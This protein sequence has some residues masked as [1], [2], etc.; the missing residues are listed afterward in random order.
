MQSIVSTASAKTI[1]VLMDGTWNEPDLV[2]D[3]QYPQGD[4]T[5]IEK[6]QYLI[7]PEGQK[8]LYFRGVGT[9]GKQVFKVVDGAFGNTAEE[10]VVEAY[11]QVVA[12][13]EPGDD[14]AIFGFSRGAATSRILARKLHDEG[15]AG[16][17][18]VIRFLGLFDTVAA[19]GV[20]RPKLDEFRKKFH[21]AKA[22]LQIPVEV[23][24]VVH[25]VAIDED[26]ALFEPTLLS[27]DSSDTKADE[28]W[29]SG[30]HGDI[31]GGWTKERADEKQ[32]AAIAL[33]YMI[34]AAES[35]GIG[36]VDWQAEVQVP[37]NGE[38]TVHSISNVT[39]LAGG[40]IVRTLVSFGSDKPRL[41]VSVREKYES[42]STYRPKQLGSGFGGVILVDS[43]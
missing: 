29:F 22:R 8:V 41:H 38:G 19:L 13:F 26:R 6:L 40:D 12:N 2:S 16:S 17:Q 24:H 32:L 31:G 9:D 28:V 1:V 39:S 14:L 20:P 37:E 23:E 35:K 18:P 25:L 15:I 4:S 36:F 5:N 10:R 33:R 3:G 34:L 43:P 42:D 11:D 30:N 27:L 7:S 21:D